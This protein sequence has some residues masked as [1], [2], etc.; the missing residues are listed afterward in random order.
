[1]AKKTTKNEKPAAK[2]T[3][4]AGTEKARKAAL[5]EVQARIDDAAPP[6]GDVAPTAAPASA[7][8]DA[9]APDAGQ[10][11]PPSGKARG[12]GS[13]KAKESAAA[14]PA[15]EPKAKRLSALDAAAQVLAKAAKP[16]SAT[17]LVEQMATQGLWSSPSGKTPSATLYAAMIR[18]AAAKGSESRFKKVDRGMFEYAGK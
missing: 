15:K 13:K 8:P 3:A 10:Q 17:E 9:P 11:T 12:K 4:S 6:T 16:M 14:K 7:T 5:A 18:E 2:K 1:M